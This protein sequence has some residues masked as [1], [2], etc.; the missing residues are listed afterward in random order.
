LNLRKIEHNVDRYSRTPASGLV[1]LSSTGE[2]EMLS[3]QET[4]DVLSAAI[5]LAADSK[6]M[7]AGIS[8]ASVLGTLELVDNASAAGY[9]CVLIPQRGNLSGK[10]QE[11]RTFFQSVADQSPLPVIMYSTHASLLSIEAV[12]ELA[13]HPQ[14]I[15]LIDENAS[16]GRV[17]Q[18]AAAT[19][20]IS[21]EVTVTTIFTAVTGRMLTVKES[22]GAATFV[23]AE[24]L[25]GGAAL[26]TAP[27]K[28]AIKT[29]TKKVG[30]QIVAASSTAMLEGV[31]GGAVGA[32]PAFAACAPQASYEVYAAWK[33]G[34]QPLAEEKQSRISPAI[35][36][37]EEELGL[38]GIR[39]ASELT[40]YF[41]G[42]PR[43]PLLPLAGEQRE[44]VE[45]VM[46]GIRN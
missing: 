8:R 34:D 42:R 41:G 28:P 9:D 11:I 33:D 19:A 31:R 23:S 17:T 21:R 1:V 22:A 16:P 38:P 39:Y 29:R 10:P 7:I 25:G 2:P 46:Q 18:L 20:A 37:V 26:A 36:V 40:G 6:V 44:R 32:M 45:R 14:I 24:T 30:F 4:R 3:D 13:S 15:G 27:P 35:Q 5:S 43:L 12:A